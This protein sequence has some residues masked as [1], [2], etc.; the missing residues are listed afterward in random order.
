MTTV[1]SPSATRR[2]QPRAQPRARGA[3]RLSVKPHD[4]RTVLDRLYLDGS[5]KLLFPRSPGPALTAVL[6]NTAGGITGG[7][8]FDVDVDARPGCH[9]VVTTQAAERA[10]RAQP[11]ETGRV[12]TC[13]RLHPGA[14][15]DWLPQETLL[16]EECALDRR[17]SVEM[18]ANA[19]FLFC[20]PVVFGRQAMGETLSGGLFHDQVE[21]RRDSELVFADRTRLSGPIAGTL[22]G[23][24]TAGGAGA[25]ASVLLASPDADRFLA[26]ARAVLPATAGASLVRPGLLYARILATDSFELRRT[27]HPLIA[28]LS[29]DRLPRTWMI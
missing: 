16:Y 18:A 11:G 25:M 12:S 3:A 23:R 2:S 21:L 15:I 10:Y 17:L 27:L 9:V 19:R 24:A 6:L 14:R 4:G 29:G 1:I 13:L 8:R 5:M 7:D 20:E 22:S 28:L 26:P